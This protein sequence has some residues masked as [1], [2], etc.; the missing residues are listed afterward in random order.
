MACGA[1]SGLKQLAYC[2]TVVRKARVGMACGA[3][4]GLKPPFITDEQRGY[5]GR[6][7]L[8]SPFGIETDMVTHLW[9]VVVKVGMACGARSGLKHFHRC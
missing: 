4:S 2:M 9:T 7:G 5:I 6:N 3:R 8:W 1:R